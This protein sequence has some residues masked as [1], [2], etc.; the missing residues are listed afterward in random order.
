MRYSWMSSKM[1]PLGLG[2]SL[3]ERCQEK[4]NERGKKRGREGETGEGD[5]QGERE[6]Q[7]H[8]QNYFG[9]VVNLK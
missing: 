8:R 6:N 4:R 2:G 1:E 5:G 3:P 9:Q 7:N